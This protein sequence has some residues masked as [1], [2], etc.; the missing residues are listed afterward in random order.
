MVP[1]KDGIVYPPYLYHV[2]SHIDITAGVEDAAKG[3]P[4]RKHNIEDIRIP[5]PPYKTQTE[6]VDRLRELEK[7]ELEFKMRIMELGRLCTSSA[8]LA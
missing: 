2:L 8:T 7:R 5:L 4:L 1:K 6:I 3:K